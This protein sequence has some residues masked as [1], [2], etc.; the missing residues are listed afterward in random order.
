LRASTVVL[1]SLL[2]LAFTIVDASPLW[3]TDVW[4]HVALGRFTWSHG[5]P[6]HEP[7]CAFADHSGR[8]LPTAWLAQVVFFAVERAGEL[9][10]G[11]GFARRTEGGVAALRAFHGL[12]VAARFGILALAFRRRSGSLGSANV[13]LGLA[14]A[15]SLGHVAVLRPQVLGE[16]ALALLL[17]LVAGPA[18]RRTLVV[19]PCVLVFWAN[20]HGSYPIG[21]ALLGAAALAVCEERALWAAALALAVVAVGLLNPAGPSIYL[22]TLHMARHPNMETMTEWAPLQVTAGWGWHVHYLAAVASVVASLA[23]SRLRPTRLE[24]LLLPLAVAPFFQ[25]RWVAW[26][27]AVA[28]WIAARHLGAILE[29]RLPGPG[30]PNARKAII[31]GLAIVTAALLSGPVRWLRT[32]SPD[33]LAR[34]TSAGTPWQVAIALVDSRGAPADAAPLASEVAARFPGGKFSGTVF[35]TERTGDFLVWALTAETPVTAYSHVHQFAPDYWRA[36]R[37]ARRAEPGWR[38]FLDR[39]RANLVVVEAEHPSLRDVLAR[40]PAW[41]VV[42]DERLFVAVRTTPLP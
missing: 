13:A 28:P 2:A 24:L 21:L 37:S 31:A 41:I 3:Y 40:D 27:V 22:D 5:I 33:S 10:A 23:L 4:G 12:V 29:K 42:L 14:L 26:W 35:T 38:D 6:E 18:T 8:W 30:E 36:W 20:V 34:S 1:I 7:L 9:L 17:V 39:A 15:L 25:Q 32:G 19:A 16:I 11:G